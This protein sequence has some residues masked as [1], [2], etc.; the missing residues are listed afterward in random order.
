MADALPPW[1]A[2]LVEQYESNAANQFIIY[3]NIHDRTLIPGRHGL[4]A[5]R[6]DRHA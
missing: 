2:Q 6:E 3:G 1:A 4:D 5:V